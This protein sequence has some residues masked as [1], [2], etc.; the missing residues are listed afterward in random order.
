MSGL[1]MNVSP[2][3]ADIRSEVLSCSHALSKLRDG[4]GE[5][6]FHSLLPLARN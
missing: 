2:S 1:R 4:V 5:M 6:L 3:T